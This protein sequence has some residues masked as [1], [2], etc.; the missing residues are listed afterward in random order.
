MFILIGQRKSFVTPQT[1]LYRGL[2]YQGSTAQWNLGIMKGQGAGKICL[3]LR[4]FIKLRFFF[5]Y[6]RTSRKRPPKMQR[7][8]RR[9]RGVVVYKNQ[10]TR[11]LFRQEVQ[12]NL[13]YGG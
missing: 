2:L 10:T 1:L 7:L 9:L 4:G 5:K 13:L 6:S 12:A 11:G 3:Q 8:S